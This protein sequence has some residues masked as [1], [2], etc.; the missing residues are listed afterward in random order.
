MALPDEESDMSL[1]VILHAGDERIGLLDCQRQ[2]HLDLSDKAAIAD[3]V[4]TYAIRLDGE[5]IGVIRHRYG[6]G[7][8]KLLAA[9]AR[10]AAR[11]QKRKPPASPWTW[12][13]RD[14]LGGRI[15]RALAADDGGLTV[16]ELISAAGLASLPRQRAQTWTGSA[17]RRYEQRGLVA[18]AGHVPGHWQMPP[19]PLWKITARGRELIAWQD[20]RDG[21]RT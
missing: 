10:L 9:A 18:R 5:L 14:S 2:E 4:C 19:S 17:L 20:E 7:A 15:V 6:A 16:N 13:Q 12:T 1:W 3:A 8:W 11:H 21:G